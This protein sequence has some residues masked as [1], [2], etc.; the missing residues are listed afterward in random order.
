MLFTCHSKLRE[1]IFRQPPDC[2][3]LFWLDAFTFMEFRLNINKSTHAIDRK[4]FSE[5]FYDAKLCRVR[6][7]FPGVVD[8]H[9]CWMV[10]EGRFVFI[11]CDIIIEKVLCTKLFSKSDYYLKL[12][13]LRIT[14][15]T[16]GLRISCMYYWITWT[17]MKYALKSFEKSLCTP[18]C[19]TKLNAKRPRDSGQIY[20]LSSF[21]VYRRFV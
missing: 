21:D 11:P 1:A 20:R 18:L 17:H 14:V 8:D 3:V 19:K 6:L 12:K 4:I 9:H 16:F 15:K 13:G 7:T 2:S 10:S 5:Y